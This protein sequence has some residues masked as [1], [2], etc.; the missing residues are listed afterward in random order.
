MRAVSFPLLIRM[1]CILLAVALIGQKSGLLHVGGLFPP[2]CHSS[3][4][5]F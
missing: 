4:W 2:F 5:L 3:D 1:W